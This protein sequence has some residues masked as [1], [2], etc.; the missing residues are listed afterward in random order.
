MTERTQ[1]QKELE[2]YQISSSNLEKAIEIIL[3]YCLQLAELWRNAEFY[4]RL[5]LQNMMFPKGI[6]Y[7]FKKQVFRTAKTN[8]FFKVIPLL[9]GEMRHKKSGANTNFS[10][11]SALVIVPGFEPGTYSLEGCCSIQLSYG[12]LKIVP[13]VRS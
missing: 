12:T 5:K 2:N 11:H 13:D 9:S 1:V 6:Q 3:S 10:N 4:K 8:I 7:D